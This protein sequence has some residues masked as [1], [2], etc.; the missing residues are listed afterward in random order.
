MKL[1]VS[2]EMVVCLVDVGL[3]FLQTQAGNGQHWTRT[4]LSAYNCILNDAR[5]YRSDRKSLLASQA[6]IKEPFDG[7]V[8]IIGELFEGARCCNDDRRDNTLGVTRS[9]RKSTAKFART[10]Y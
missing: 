8:G 2:W 5:L 4:A 7:F 10:K 6:G 9:S 3:E 1:G